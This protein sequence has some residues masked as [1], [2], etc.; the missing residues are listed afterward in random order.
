MKRMFYYC[1]K[2]FSIS[3][4]SNWVNKRIISIKEM[5]SGCSSL[6]SLPDLSFW[7]IK[8]VKSL[9]KMFYNCSS[10][11]YFF[12]FQQI[13]TQITFRAILMTIKCRMDYIKLIFIN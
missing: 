7:N 2:L 13:K 10:L 12:S 3:C 5:Y 4:S 11:N 6:T 9:E 8:K 1:D